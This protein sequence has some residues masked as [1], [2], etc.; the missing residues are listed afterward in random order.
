VG[1]LVGVESVRERT[2]GKEKGGR[3]RA[4]VEVKKRATFKGTEISCIKGAL[5]EGIAL[6]GGESLGST[7][8]IRCAPV[9]GKYDPL[10]QPPV[11]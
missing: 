4:G 9:Q 1:W 5:L 6:G 3:L 2:G 10:D 7:Q 8:T 11:L